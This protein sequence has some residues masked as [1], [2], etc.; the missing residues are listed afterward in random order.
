M[1]DSMELSQKSNIFNFFFKFQISLE[2]KNPNTKKYKY[3]KILWIKYFPLTSIQIYA[4]L[5]DN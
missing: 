3:A 2:K 4:N 1:E 5:N